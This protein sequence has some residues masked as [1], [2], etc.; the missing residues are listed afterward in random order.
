[1][2]I[3]QTSDPTPAIQALSDRLIQELSQN[4][5]VLWFVSGGS[6][7]GAAVKIMANIGDD[8]SKNLIVTTIDERF[9]PVGH[10][11]SNWQQLQDAGFA[12]KQATLIPPLQPEE[13]LETAAARFRDQL[14]QAFASCDISIA[15]LGMGPD[16]HISG[17]LPNS[18]ATDLQNDIVVGYVSDPYE[19]IT[20]TFTALA[21]ISVFYLFAYGENKREQLLAL[22]DQ[23]LDYDT[24][25][26]QF[27]KEMPEVY[28]YNDQIGEAA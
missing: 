7:I 27:L 10:P 3:I 21:K 25:P 14:A 4:K 1:M 19:R 20:T 26:A 18:V 17:I 6:N 8:L 11:D 28:V 22:R 23:T 9:G 16:G 5:K 15:L 12:P 13:T 2:Q 24:Q